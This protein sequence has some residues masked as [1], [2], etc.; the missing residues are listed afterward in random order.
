ME[1]LRITLLTRKKLQRLR[2][3]L[4]TSVKKKNEEAQHVNVKMREANNQH[5][6]PD[7]YEFRILAVDL[8]EDDTE[9]RVW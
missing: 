7:E 2:S 5:P 8:P 3:L 6:Y 9:Q 4:Q 1:L